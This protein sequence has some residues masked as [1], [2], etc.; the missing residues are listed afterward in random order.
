MVKTIF[1]IALVCCMLP[2]WGATPPV[3]AQPTAKAP[4]WGQR[5]AQATPAQTPTQSASQPHAQSATPAKPLWGEPSKPATAAAPTAAAATKPADTVTTKPAIAATPA[6][7]AAV[8]PAAATPSLQLPQQ[9]ASDPQALRQQLAATIAAAQDYQKK[10]QARLQ[11]LQHSNANLQQRLQDLQTRYMQL[12][13][14][15]KGTAADPKTLKDQ[16]DNRAS[17]VSDLRWAAILIV[18]GVVL[19]FWLLWSQRRG[20]AAGGGPEMRAPKPRQ[21]RGPARPPQAAPHPEDFARGPEHEFAA[22]AFDASVAAEPP[23]KAAKKPRKKAAPKPKRPKAASKAAPIE[24]QPP[25]SLHEKPGPAKKQGDSA[26]A[27]AEE[28][29]ELSE[30]GDYDYMSTDEAI[31]AKLD[32]ARAYIDME[33][34]AAAKEVLQEVLKQGDQG[35]RN[36][37]QLLLA[38][39]RDRGAA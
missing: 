10:M 34:F 14:Q 26:A 23:P 25:A 21:P 1:S 17:A 30:E 13:K 5:T 38:K 24:K 4:L 16:L 35:Q 28:A 3:T 12:T 7:S 36:E 33:D 37:A 27:H 15:L 6:A 2:V 22:G 39:L 20:R 31:P 11:Q 19:L 18:V 8:A 29:G 32:L 9:P